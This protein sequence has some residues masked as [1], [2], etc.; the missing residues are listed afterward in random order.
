MSE[1]TQFALA[2]VGWSYGID[3]D[4]QL[5]IECNGKQFEVVLSPDTSPHETIEGLLLKRLG[6]AL[7]L[8]DDEEQIAI[9]E[10]IADIVCETG[11]PTFERLAPLVKSSPS[12]PDL[13]SF[14]HPGT[15]SFQLVTVHGK[16]Q[17][18]K[19]KGG[20]LK[21]QEFTLHV[22]HS[23]LPRI[24][25]RDI[26]ILKPLRN[27]NITKVLVHGQ[28]R[29]CKIADRITEQAV[30]REFDCLSKIAL[31]NLGSLRVP[32]LVGLVQSPSNDAIIG[33][34]EEYICP[35]PEIGQRTLRRMDIEN[36]T[37]VR[38]AKWA[39]QVRETVEI[40]HGIGIIWGDGKADNVLI[41]VNDD[42]WLIDFGGGWTDK[43]VDEKLTGTV[44]GDRQ[45][46]ENIK[47]FLGA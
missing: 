43:W 9:E 3:C 44:E 21:A 12:L 37:D 13:H 4:C 15:F 32:K 22:F 8:R 46:V 30:Q 45:A 24:C 20:A 31:A 11:L 2:V 28:E 1:E 14:L 5:S 6:A 19:R 41:D 16:P 38:R 26:Q 35:L 29:C 17:I 23:S 25:S 36:I 33:I 40:L 7:K 42:A 10:E 47:R 18:V 27:K 34:L 39:S